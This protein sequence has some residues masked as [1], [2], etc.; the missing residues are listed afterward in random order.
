MLKKLFSMMPGLTYRLCRVVFKMTARY[1]L[2]TFSSIEKHHWSILSFIQSHSCLLSILDWVLLGLLRFYKYVSNPKNPNF[3]LN[4]VKIG[5]FTK[6]MENSYFDVRRHC[7]QIYTNCAIQ[8][9]RYS[10]D[11]CSFVEKKKC[12][13]DVFQYVKKSP[14]CSGQ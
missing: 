13:N 11:S 1:S 8:N 9:L 5:Y 14:D 3:H 2:V 4:A 12:S 7:C 6:C 10:K